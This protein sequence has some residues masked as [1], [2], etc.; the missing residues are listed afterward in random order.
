MMA[1]VSAETLSRY[2]DQ[3]VSES[4]REEVQA[5]IAEDPAL[6][7]EVAKLRSL[8]SVLHEACDAMLEEDIELEVRDGIADLLAQASG[9]ER[10]QR[11][12][13]P[14]RSRPAWGR[15]AAALAASLVALLLAGSLGYRL[16]EQ[17]IAQEQVLAAAQQAQDRRL[18]ESAFDQALDQHLSGTPAAWENSQTGSYGEVTPLRTFKNGDGNWCRE[19]REVT[20]VGGETE[21]RHGIACRESPGNW[22]TRVFT[23]TDV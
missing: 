16:A 15:R 22:R 2:L 13:A 7:E 3:E 9:A 17:K 19:Y 5:A 11:A 21:T 12:P 6:A 18:A 8:D 20:V 14:V 1:K 10:P 4:E 23:D